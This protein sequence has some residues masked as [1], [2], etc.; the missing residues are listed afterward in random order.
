MSYQSFKLKV[1]ASAGHQCENSNCDGPAE[2]VHHFLKQSLY[3]QYREDPDDGMACCGRCHSEIERRERE[4]EDV[5][6]L[7]PI[8]RYRSMLL[9]AGIEAPGGM[10]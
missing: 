3:P 7:Y 6:E 2:T 4:G 9:K 1:F 8:G 5:L 10:E